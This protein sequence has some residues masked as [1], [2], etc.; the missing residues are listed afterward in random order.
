MNIGEEAWC[1]DLLGDRHTA[2]SLVALEHQDLE[3][4]AREIAGASEPIMP[5]PDHD[6]FVCAPGI[7]LS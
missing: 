1:R 4:G 5:G 6:G 7:L 2:I 3:A